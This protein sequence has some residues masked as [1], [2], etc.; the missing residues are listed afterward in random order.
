MELDAVA[1]PALI[2]ADDGW[3]RYV[4]TAFNLSEWSSSAVGKYTIFCWIAMP[5][6]AGGCAT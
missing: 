5:A 6:P 4:Q 3:V 2:V 1:L